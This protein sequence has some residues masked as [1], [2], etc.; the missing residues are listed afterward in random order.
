MAAIPD[1]HRDDIL[2]VAA[3]H[4]H[5]WALGSRARWYCRRCGDAVRRRRLGR[6]PCLH[7]GTQSATSRISPRSAAARTKL[8]SVG[9]PATLF[10]RSLA[11]RSTLDWPAQPARCAHIH[12]ATTQRRAR[13][14]HRLQPASAR[15][16]RRRYGASW[17]RRSGR[18]DNLTRRLNQ[19]NS[20]NMRG[21]LALADKI[22]HLSEPCWLLTYRLRAL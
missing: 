8:A 13:V 4:Q 12:Q 21:F 3:G 1:D 2:S 18:R 11:A 7:S 17:R 19:I 6:D 5:F 10:A 22:I 15:Q 20:S 14:L 16:W 9:S